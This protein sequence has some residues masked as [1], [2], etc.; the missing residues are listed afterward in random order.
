MARKKKRERSIRR[1]EGRVAARAAKK[2][3]NTTDG[4]R[5]AILDGLRSMADS[6]PPSRERKIHCGGDGQR[7][8]ALVREDGIEIVG[9]VDLGQDELRVYV[10]DVD[11][12]PLLDRMEHD[13]TARTELQRHLGAVTQDAVVDVIVALN[14]VALS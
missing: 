14:E 7:T 12:S 11:V 10:N 8:L 9:E 2:A 5:A 3:E 13:E 1:L 4:G 6:S